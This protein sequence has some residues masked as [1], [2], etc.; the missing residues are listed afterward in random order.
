MGLLQLREEEIF[1]TLSK[2]LKYKFVLIGGYSVN[3]YTLPRFSVDCDIVVKDKFE[4]KK[5]EKELI[6]LGY[7]R[8]KI[9]SHLSYHGEFIRYEKEIQTNFEVSVDILF[10]KILDRQTNSTFY[11]DWVFENSKIREIKGKTI[12]NKLKLRVINIDSLIVMKMISARNTDIRDVFMLI[13]KAETI[14]WIKQ[15][16][17][18]RYDF[19]N[20]FNKINDKITSKQ[21]KDNLQ[22]VYGHI[23]NALFEKHKKS[24]LELN[25]KSKMHS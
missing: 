11:A 8:E 2:I 12:T 17:S 6:K 25:E 18:K 4:L 16:V 1:K 3:A 24:F 23:D 13:P 7:K 9:A 10:D 15:E 21:F 22:G 20:R 19:Q 14:G 5:I